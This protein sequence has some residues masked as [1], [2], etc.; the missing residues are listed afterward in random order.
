MMAS[1]SEPSC[2][3][4]DRTGPLCCLPDG[5]VGPHRFKCCAPA[6]PGYGWAAS[7]MPHPGTTC[8][9]TPTPARSIESTEPP[10]ETGWYA[11]TTL[12]HGSELVQHLYVLFL[13]FDNT[14][15]VAPSPHPALP[16]VESPNAPPKSYV[17]IPGVDGLVDP[18][19][20]L[21]WG[22]RV[23]H[24]RVLMGGAVIAHA[25]ARAA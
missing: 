10:T 5:H 21:T 17:L 4:P 16:A 3:G 20:V 12:Q 11:A 19:R 15:R 8:G 25:I 6:C 9:P 18:A 14:N 24:P 1:E 7:A 22:P 13:A 23:D 2:A